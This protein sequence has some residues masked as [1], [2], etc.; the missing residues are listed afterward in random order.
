MEQV[1][2]ERLQGKFGVHMRGLLGEAYG[3]FVASFEKPRVSSLRLNERKLSQE[4]FAALSPFPVT[5]IPWIRGG[6]FYAYE[7]RPS[8][9][10]LYQ[11][12]AYYLQDAGAMTPGSALPIQPGDRVID[13][14]AAPGGKATAAGA[15]LKGRGILVANDYSATRAKALL[16]NIELFGIANAIVTSE[17]VE[18]LA[19]RFP[20]AFDKVILDAPCSGEGM[21]RKDAS[22]AQDWTDEKSIGL[23]KLQ[24]TLLEEAW[25]M[26]KPGGI[27]LYSTCTYELREDEEVVSSLLENHPEARLLPPP[28]Y[29]G[30]QEG[31]GLPEAVRIYPH[32][33]QAEGHFFALIQK[34]R[35]QE[36]ENLEQKDRRQEEEA[37]P[38]RRKADK[39]KGTTP[40]AN[41]ALE[42]VKAFFAEAG[43]TS[44]GEFPVDWERVEIRGER[45]YLLPG[46]VSLDRNKKG[47]F[48]TLDG[49]SLAG[50]GF[51]RLGLYLGELKKDRFEPGQPL[52]LALLPGDTA[53]SIDLSLGDPRLS[54]YLSGESIEVGAEDAAKR[55]G[56]CLLTVEGIPLAFG[57]RVGNTLKNKIPA[58]WRTLG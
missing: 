31:I 7:D 12:G 1:I 35:P 17:P 13:L 41:P 38:T 29:E 34:D 49:I 30:Y 8:R 45:A 5:P 10:P 18:E 24:K 19:K 22:L 51:L 47:T 28:P 4:A 21:F 46:V 42:T 20:A 48:P 25:E 33:M 32:R 27:L 23:S 44:I 57:K 15:A 26:L 50:L 3:D 40:K 43:I 37:A 2:E 55:E 36:E 52:A 16:R 9:N 14:C 56:Y 53:Y 58:A 39:K 54:R 6:Y 11:A